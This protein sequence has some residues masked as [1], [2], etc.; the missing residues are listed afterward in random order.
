MVLEKIERPEMSKEPIS[1]PPAIQQAL[2]EISALLEK[3]PCKVNRDWFCQ[4]LLEYFKFG[5]KLLVLRSKLTTK[6]GE[7]PM[8]DLRFERVRQ[9]TRPSTV[10]VKCHAPSP[11]A[12]TRWC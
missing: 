4:S 6:L 5:S 3:K 8:S 10:H 11:T 1:R 12:S 9:I 2:P 7:E